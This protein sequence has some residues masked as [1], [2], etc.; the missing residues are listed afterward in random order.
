M[1]LVIEQGNIM[2]KR[3]AY[4]LV[5]IVFVISFSFLLS[6]NS[7]ADGI[8][9]VPETFQE[10]SQWCWDASSKANL[11]YY[12]AGVSQCTIANWKLGRSDCCGNTDFYWHHSCNIPNTMTATR[13]VHAHWGV[14][15]D[16]RYYGLSQETVTSEIDAGRPFIM[17]FAWSGGGGHI[18]SGRGIMGDNVYYMD[19]WLGNGYTISTYSWVLNG[20][21]HTWVQSLQ[22][23]T[24]LSSCPVCPADGVIN[25]VT[26]AAGKTCSCSH[27]ISITLGSNVTVESGAI[28]TFTAP[29]VTV[30]PGFHGANGSTISIIQQ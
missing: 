13:D 9:N 25:D 8:L 26:Y 21:G 27:A 4:L 20:T 24:N 16:V 6:S 2:K 17:G 1:V 15:G 19:P 10:H 23:S 7:F 11:D 28:V 14:N 22:L 29:K 30:Q 5:R 12:E 3:G 18:L